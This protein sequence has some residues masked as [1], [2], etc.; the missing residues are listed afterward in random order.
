[1]KNIELTKKEG[2]VLDT[3]EKYCDDYIYVYPKL[4][5]KEITSNGTA[6]AD[7]GYVGLGSVTV[8][9]STTVELPTLNAPTISLN[10]STLTITN[11]ATNGNFVSSYKVYDGSTLL[12]AVTN[13]SVNLSTL[14]TAA[15]THTITVKASGTNF[16]DSVASNSVSYTVTLSTLSTPTISLVSDTTIQ[17][18]T[19]DDNAT[20]IE[21]FADGLS[22]GEVTKEATPLIN[23]SIEGGN[24]SAEEGMT[25]GE[26]VASSYN[27]AN[28]VIANTNQIQSSTGKYVAVADVRVTTDEAIIANKSYM[29]SSAVE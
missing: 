14:I 12:T 7:D 27:T 2:V 8:N 26:W 25:W 17:I 16:N 10:N 18:D 20:T 23:F 21:V 24:Y 19:I 1:M 15:G 5:S 11:P 6:T 22:I 28:F 29:L 9:V 4:Q 13:T 3:S